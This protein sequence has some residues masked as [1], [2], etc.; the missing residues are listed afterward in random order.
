MSGMAA[1]SKQYR[2]V[3]VNRRNNRDA[4]NH[5]RVTREQLHAQHAHADEH[6]TPRSH[7]HARMLDLP[8]AARFILA[9]SWLCRYH[10]VGAA[11]RAAH[12]F[13][14]HILPTR[15]NRA[16]PHSRLQR[17]TCLRTWFIVTR[18]CRA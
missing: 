7:A 6:A 14:L 11:R 2:N 16:L 18:G 12:W 1:A 15:L 8:H 17:Q 5:L 13:A 9:Y 4:F 10:L 3:M